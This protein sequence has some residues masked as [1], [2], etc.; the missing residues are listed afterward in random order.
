MAMYD[1][2]IDFFQRR[3]PHLHQ[4]P[5]QVLNPPL[6]IRSILKVLQKLLI[7]FDTRRWHPSFRPRLELGV[8]Q[9]LRQYPSS[10]THHLSSNLIDGHLMSFALS[11]GEI[12]GQ[13]LCCFRDDLV[14]SG[15][16]FE[17]D[18]PMRVHPARIGHYFCQFIGLGGIGDLDGE[19]HAG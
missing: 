15:A 4:I 1:S 3:I 12:V 10:R 14:C 9:L 11:T 18:F 8:S 6:F 17:E 19:G 2:R 7:V 5:P 16:L 13:T